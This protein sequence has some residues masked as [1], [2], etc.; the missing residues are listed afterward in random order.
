MIKDL[1]VNEKGK[2]SRKKKEIIEN[3]KGISYI[4]CTIFSWQ[5]SVVLTK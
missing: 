2:S 3:K 1:N 4:F 5:S